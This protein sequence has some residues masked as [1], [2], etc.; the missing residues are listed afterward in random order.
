MKNPYEL[1]KN[2]LQEATEKNESVS[3]SGGFT[4]IDLYGASVHEKGKDDDIYNFPQQFFH[5]HKSLKWS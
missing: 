4:S 3:L 5:S 1:A 2:I